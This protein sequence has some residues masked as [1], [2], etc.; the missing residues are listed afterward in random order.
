M[1]V[2][3][4]P[5][6][7]QFRELYEADYQEFALYS[8]RSAGK[9]RAVAQYLIFKAF[10]SNIRI[11]CVREIKESAKDSVFK[12]LKDAASDFNLEDAFVFKDRKIICKRT[13]SDIIYRGV[14]RN[15][16]SLKSL[17]GI[18]ICWVEEAQTVSQEALDI[19]LPTIFR[20]KGA[21]VIYTYNPRMSTDAVYKRFNSGI[22]PPNSIVKR[23]DWRQNVYFRDKMKEEMDFAFKYD[24]EMA[25][26]IWEG[27]LCPSPNDIAVLPQHWLRQS[28]EAY[29]KFKPNLGFKYMGLDFADGGKDKSA[30]AYRK[31]PVVHDAFEFESKF[32]SDAVARADGYAKMHDSADN[33]QRVLDLYFDA[34]GIGAGAKDDFNRIANRYYI[35]HP[36][37]G[38]ASPNGANKKFTDTMTN[39]Q[40]FRNLKAQ[41][42]WHLR[43]RLENTLRLLDGNSVRL[44]EC[45]FISDATMSRD[46]LEKLIRELGQ[47]SYKHEDG[48]LM[49]DKAPNAKASPNMADAV[50]MAFLFDMKNGLRAR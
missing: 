35:A 30:I 44:E 2:R 43:L 20:N 26:H 7:A 5:S 3:K 18:N 14:Y 33:R 39:G 42:W 40:F 9:S 31:G 17:S 23:V 22:T 10:S 32:I 36:H 4:G 6:Q 28:I 1:G 24:P 12:D 11:L 21:K 37:V 49:V 15:T 19:L 38:S 41:A 47:A 50:V 45:F 27:E 46:S 34:I 13:G 16:D 25:M 8:G 29:K 48:K